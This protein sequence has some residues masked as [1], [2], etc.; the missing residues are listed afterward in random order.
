MW[1]LLRLIFLYFLLRKEGVDGM[2]FALVGARGALFAI[3]W[4]SLSYCGTGSL[5]PPFPAQ[6]IRPRLPF[7]IFVPPCLCSKLEPLE[8]LEP[9]SASVNCRLAACALPVTSSYDC[10]SV[11][12][13][14]LW[15]FSHFWPL[16]SSFLTFPTSSFRAF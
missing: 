11:Y 15:D 13:L 4:P 16:C 8:P 14:P 6:W 3:I 9:C 10:A 12:L 1:L 2:L 7:V 5:L